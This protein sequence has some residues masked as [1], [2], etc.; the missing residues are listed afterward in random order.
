VTTAQRILI[1]STGTLLAYPPTMEQATSATVRVRTPSTALPAAGV[2]ATVDPV[3]GTVDADAT[4][5]ATALVLEEAQT[6]VRGRQYLV[7]VTTGEVF[8]VTCA[9][10]GTTAT[11][12]MTEP[13]P[14][15]VPA[16][17]A[18][19]GY[20]LTRQLSTD[21]TSARGEG[22]A[23]WT[24]ALPVSGSQTFGTQLRIVRRVPRYTLTTGRLTSSWPLVN[25]LRPPTD[26]D[27]TEVLQGVWDNRVVPA[28]E[29]KGIRAEQVIS[30]EALEPV[31]AAAIIAHLMA[32]DTA[33][34]REDVEYWDGRLREA[35]D[36][37]VSGGGFWV[38]D[39]DEQAAPRAEDAAPASYTFT[40]IT[41]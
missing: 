25:Q 18:V 10:A 26:V 11:L 34:P 15:P 17:S 41:R 35:M 16:G 20:A 9:L 6:F 28:L 31:H 23:L 7:V 2:T 19:L 14:L 40:R 30:A 27:M 37:A 32:M 3:D 24:A 36:L 5:G 21:E 33:R 12:R 22:L 39:E 38:D 13:L 4:E 8:A 1:S 29:A